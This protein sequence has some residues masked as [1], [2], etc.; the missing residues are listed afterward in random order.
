MLRRLSLLALNQ[1]STE[2]WEVSVPHVLQVADGSA[3]ERTSRRSDLWDTTLPHY[4]SRGPVFKRIEKT[5]PFR[6]LCSQ[7]KWNSGEGKESNT[8][9]CTN[10]LAT[11][12][13]RQWGKNVLNVMCH[14]CFKFI[15]HLKT[16][17]AW[18]S[19]NT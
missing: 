4:Q 11:N 19:S 10:F 8:F 12:I 1:F 3:N 13:S 14:S 18:P 7:N 9:T 15:R 17:I 5:R 2:D 6:L 16:R